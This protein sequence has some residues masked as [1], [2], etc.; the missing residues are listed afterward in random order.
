M[1]LTADALRLP[2]GPLCLLAACLGLG[3]ACQSPSVIF[4]NGR[5]ENRCQTPVAACGIQARCVLGDDEYLRGTFPGGVRFLVRNAQTESEGAR[6]T[7]RVLFDN[8][9]SGGTEFF[10][11]VNEV[12]CSDFTEEQV[13]EENVL[14]L[15]GDD[16]V[17]EYD[18]EVEQ[19]GDHLIEV[20][21]DA[22]ANYFLA[23]I[24]RD[25]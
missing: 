1:S 5:L 24:V 8:A 25:R 15:A 22:T 10:A 9:T 4:T 2:L 11:Q 19:R 17:L 18:F 13:L 20:F 23:V 3:S 6:I 16:L 14:D 21:S 7:L 12:G